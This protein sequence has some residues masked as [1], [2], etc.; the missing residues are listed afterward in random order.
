M[1]V[2]QKAGISPTTDVTCSRE[3]LVR[4][5]TLCEHENICV[6]SLEPVGPCNSHGMYV[7]LSMLLTQLPT[8]HIARRKWNSNIPASNK[9]TDIFKKV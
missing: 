2:K 7:Y 8:R 4:T 9:N 1:L 6:T 3:K 5:Y